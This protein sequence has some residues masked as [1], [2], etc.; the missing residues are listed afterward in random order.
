MSRRELKNHIPPQHL[1]AEVLGETDRVAAVEG[2]ALA[3][4]AGRHGPHCER[5]LVAQEGIVSGRPH[6]EA[7]RDE[8]NS[9]R[10]TPDSIR[11]AGGGRKKVERI[12]GELRAMHRGTLP[13][14][15][16]KRIKGWGAYYG[17]AAVETLT[18]V[19]FRDKAVMAEMRQH[20]ELKA[21]LRPFA[22]G[23][24][25]LAV[26]P[27]DALEKLLLTLDQL[28]IKINQRL[29]LVDGDSRL[30]SGTVLTVVVPRKYAGME[31]S[32]QDDNY[33]KSTRFSSR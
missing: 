5:D 21:I 30:E 9:W 4:R 33:G 23:D 3:R 22:A 15:L 24:R 20:P 27:A 8:D 11:Q 2:Q 7:E 14:D 13:R 18:L 17:E 19:E 28:G 26:V 10:L 32:E 12:L 29:G 16:I 1:P 25:A 31:N 6:R